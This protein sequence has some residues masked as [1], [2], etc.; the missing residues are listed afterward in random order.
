MS[1]VPPVGLG[2]VRRPT[3]R[4][5]RDQKDQPKVWKWSKG[6]HGGSGGVGRPTRRYGRDRDVLG[7][8]LEG[9]G[10]VKR[11]TRRFGRGWENYPKDRRGRQAYPEV[12][13]GL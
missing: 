6:Q 8:P 12:R 2:G 13:E 4:S 9:S 7:C 11:P 1:G 3:R 5:E 10:G